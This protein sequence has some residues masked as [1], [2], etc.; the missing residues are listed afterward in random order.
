MS[1]AAS[2]LLVLE[3][4]VEPE[5]NLVLCIQSSLAAVTVARLMPSPMNII[6]LLEINSLRT[7]HNSKAKT[8]IQLAINKRA[9]ARIT[10]CKSIL[11]LNEVF[12]LC[13]VFFDC[14]T[15]ACFLTRL[16]YV[17]FENFKF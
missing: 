4:I 3:A 16:F 8:D 7:H 2:P 12:F 5:S 14:I 15:R 6:T 17:W 10:L 1:P 9:E 13:L 11:V